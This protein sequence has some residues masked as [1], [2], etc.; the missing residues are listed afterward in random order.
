VGTTPASGKIP[1]RNSPQLLT[2]QRAVQTAPAACR[3]F[4]KLMLGKRRGELR[5]RPSHITEDWVSIPTNP[6][7]RLVPASRLSPLGSGA[8]RTAQ[9]K[10]PMLQLREK[11]VVL[12]DWS[13][14]AHHRRSEITSLAPPL[15]TRRSRPLSREWSFYSSRIVL[16]HSLLGD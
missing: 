6:Y 16:A 7:N 9:L 15:R 8:C 12:P 13:D 1:S 10:G 11:V 5:L 2:H 4:A 14:G 3:A